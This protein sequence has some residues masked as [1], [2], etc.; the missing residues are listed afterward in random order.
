GHRIVAQLARYPVRGKRA[1]KRVEIRV[2]RHLERQPGAARLVGPVE[3]DD[4]LADLGG[5]EGPAVLAFGQHQAVD[6]R[7]VVD[8]LL[9][10]RRLERR[11]PDPSRLDHGLSPRLRLS[12]AVP[13]SCLKAGTEISPTRGSADPAE[14]RAPAMRWGRT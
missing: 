9:Q 10:V 8:G 4:Q 6:L 11:V 14:L 7:V 5:Q 2:R 13:R 3:P 12:L 1:G